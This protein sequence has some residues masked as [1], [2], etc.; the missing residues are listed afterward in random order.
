M[1]E[2]EPDPSDTRNV[3]KLEGC[4]G[5]V[6]LFEEALRSEEWP[7]EC[8]KVQDQYH[9]TTYGC[10]RPLGWNDAV[11]LSHFESRVTGPWW[12]AKE[13]DLRVGQHL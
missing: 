10:C 5:V 2:V 9:Q 7:A 12:E 1:R 11:A 3:E 4:V 6:E 13:G 8:D